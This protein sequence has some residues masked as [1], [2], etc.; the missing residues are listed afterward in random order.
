MKRLFLI[1]ALAI[2]LGSGAYFL[3]YHVTQTM[4]CR[5]PDASEPWSWTRQ[6]FHLSDAEYAQVKKLETD[7]H[8]RCLELCDQI[9]QS[10]MALKKLILANSQITPE[11]AAALLILIGA[12]LLP[13][14]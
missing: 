10:H 2:F 1:L 3:S 11:V 6:E 5:M 14:E 4:F 8:P 12:D 9:E 13:S 7:Y